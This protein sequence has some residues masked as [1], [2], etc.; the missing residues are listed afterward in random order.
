[1]FPWLP[2]A[3]GQHLKHHTSHTIDANVTTGDKCDDLSS[4]GQID[5]LL[6]P[7]HFLGELAGNELLLWRPWAQEGKVATVTENH[8]TLIE[9][10]VSLVSPLGPSPWPEADQIEE[11]AVVV[12]HLPSS[13]T[14]TATV[15]LAILTFSMSNFVAPVANR[16]AGS[17]T[18]W[19]P[20]E[21]RA[22]TEG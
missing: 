10:Q 21:R 8:F 20:T 9:C 12:G 16:A 7:V 18:P 2:P 11:A 3:P 22:Q 13:S 5:R 19:A 14:A 17:A 1:M 4:G 15:T 6:C